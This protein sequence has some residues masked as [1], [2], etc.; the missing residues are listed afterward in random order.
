VLALVGLALMLWGLVDP[1]AM[2]VLVGLTIGQAIG[3]GSFLLFLIVIAAD[4]HIR[5][6]LAAGPS[7]PPPPMAKSD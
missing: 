5:R 2:P 4:L 6:R 7:T 3:T 1:H